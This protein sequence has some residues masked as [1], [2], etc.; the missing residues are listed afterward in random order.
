MSTALKRL[1]PFFFCL[2]LVLILAGCAAPA[3]ASPAPNGGPKP[4]TT[5]LSPPD[6][7]GTPAPE[8]SPAPSV[9]AS[10]Q[11]TQSIPAQPSKEP[12][13][14]PTESTSPAPALPLYTFGTPLAETGVVEDTHFDT[15]AF[16]GDSRTEG[17]Q[18]FGGLY[19]GDYFWARGMTVFRV[20]NPNYAIFDV[21]GEMVTMIGALGKKEYGSVYIMVGV[22]EL[23]YDAGSYESGLGKFIDLVLEVQ[24]NAVVYLQTLPPVNEEVARKNGLAS[25]INNDRIN[26]FNEAIV[27]VAAEKKVVLLDTAQVYRDENGSLPADLAS[28]GCHF[29]YGGYARWTDYLRCHVMDGETYHHNRTLEPAPEPTGSPEPSQQPPADPAPSEEPSPTGTPE[30]APEPSTQPTDEVTEV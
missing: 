12:D 20:D 30:P 10:P 23:G 22:N 6:E 21:D 11:P 25:Y 7:T 3:P 1:L 2:V 24:P 9:P 18:L 15:A 4:G 13:T 26:Q 8:A 28:D 16:L 19:H 17:L 5:A 29:N 14:A 27:R